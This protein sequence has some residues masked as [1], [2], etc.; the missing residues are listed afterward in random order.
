[1]LTKQGGASIT[2]IWLI[3]G[4]FRMD[5]EVRHRTA[6]HSDQKQAITFNSAPVIHSNLRRIDLVESKHPKPCMSSDQV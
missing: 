6:A 2:G 5:C 4:N 3:T 1:M